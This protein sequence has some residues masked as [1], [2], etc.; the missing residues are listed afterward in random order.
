MAEKIVQPVENTTVQQTQ[1]QQSEKVSSN[2]S[3]NSHSL[4]FMGEAIDMGIAPVGVTKQTEEKQEEGD[5]L[6][7][8][9]GKDVEIFVP[10][11]KASVGKGGKNN[12]D[13]VKVIQKLLYSQGYYDVKITG[14]CDQNTLNAILSFQKKSPSCSVH[15]SKVD[16]NQNT[17]KALTKSYFHPDQVQRER[18]Q[19][20]RTKNILAIP[21]NI[22]KGAPG[23]VKD[24]DKSGYDD[25]LERIKKAGEAAA[26]LNSVPIKNLHHLTAVLQ[27]LYINKVSPGVLVVVSHGGYGKPYFRIGVDVINAGALSRLKPLRNLLAPSTKLVIQAC[28]TGGGKDPKKGEAFSKSLAETLG[29]T[30]YTSRSWSV[31]VSD[32]FAG[33]RQSSYF[34]YNV[35]KKKVDAKKRPY[36]YEYMGQW[37]KT[38]PG[39]EETKVEVI[40]SLIFK[41]DG[42]FTISSSRFPTWWKEEHMKQYKQLRDIARKQLG[43]KK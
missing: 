34:H 29:V 17:W 31:G 33:K 19:F 12:P 32:L 39:K 30:T 15:D 14:V 1:V 40:N 28:H 20:S 11:I 6:D 35:E 27:H 18:K 36:V 25:Y 37:L 7:K 38:T 41:P 16:V 10:E 3:E 13:D 23:F 21:F 5:K 4:E 2:S 22:A 42:S 26:G 24:D 43:L 9:K 8:G